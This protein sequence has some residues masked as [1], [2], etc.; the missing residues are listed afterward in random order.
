MFNH[1]GAKRHVIGFR[2]AM[3][4]KVF[5]EGL[6]LWM[7]PLRLG[8]H[9]VCAIQQHVIDRALPHGAIGRGEI[10]AARTDIHHTQGVVRWRK[11][12]EVPVGGWETVLFQHLTP[13]WRGGV[14]SV[15]KFHE[16]PNVL[17][18]F[19]GASAGRLSWVGQICALAGQSGGHAPAEWTTWAGVISLPQPRR[20]SG[21]GARIGIFTGQ[22]AQ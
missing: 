20:V 2:R 3:C 21:G 16:A 13:D 18:D 17:I 7:C 11:A 8:Q 19:R 6:R 10:A 22:Q 15:I 14:V 12:G 9:A 5:A 1:M 4:C